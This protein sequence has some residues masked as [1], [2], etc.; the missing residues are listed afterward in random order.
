MILEAPIAVDKLKKP[1]NLLQEWRLPVDE[2]IPGNSDPGI[3]HVIELLTLLH[4]LVSKLV[5]F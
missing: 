1:E 3:Q 2:S 4:R 5:Q